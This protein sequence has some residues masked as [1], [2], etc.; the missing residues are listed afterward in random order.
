MLILF[1]IISPSTLDIFLF[2]KAFMSFG[3]NNN[4]DSRY[5]DSTQ[6]MLGMYQFYSSGQSYKRDRINIISVFRFGKLRHGEVCT[7]SQMVNLGFE[8]RLSGSSLEARHLP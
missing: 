5:V 7:A 2:P 6:H 1:L 4:N 8:S 3:Q